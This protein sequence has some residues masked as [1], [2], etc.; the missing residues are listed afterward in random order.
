MGI[1]TTLSR[2]GAGLAAAALAVTGGLLAA[3]TPGAASSSLATGHA[4]HALAER[5]HVVHVRTAPHRPGPATAGTGRIMLANSTEN[6]P[7]G[8]NYCSYDS[9][10]VTY[11][12]GCQADTTVDFW[13]DSNTVNVEV[14]VYSPYLFAGCRVYSQLY[15]GSTLGYAFAGNS[16]YGYGCSQTDFTCSD[17]KAEYYNNQP[18]GVPAAFLPYVESLWVADTQ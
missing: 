13:R 17:P 5:V 12:G 14:D 16:F 18:T 7:V 9:G 8:Q 1:I 10:W 11:S 6:C 2:A 4:A 15:L 3:G